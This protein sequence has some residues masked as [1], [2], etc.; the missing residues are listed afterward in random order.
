MTSTRSSARSGT[1]GDAWELAARAGFA[2]SG[3]LHVALGII[4][5]RIG[6]GAGGEADQGKALSGL[7]HSGPGTVLLWVATAA[8]V[9]LA[10]WQAAD[11][12]RGTET[13]DR[14]KAAGKAAVYLAV[15]FTAASIAMGS[16]SSDQDKQ[17]QGFASTLMQAPGG[18]LLVGAIGLGI[19]AAG[20]YHVFKGATRRF[21]RDL[22]SPSANEVGTGV[23]W[24]GTIGYVAKGVALGAVG[25]LFTYAAV[26]ADPDKAQGI[27]GAI[28]SLLGVPGGPVIVVLVGIGFAAYGVYSFA[29]ARYARM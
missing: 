26:T 10:G 15:A 5:V 6:L 22:R 9:A 2:V 17:A 1:S 12:I 28:E 14:A 13:A 4:I 27:D 19:V 8:L 29:R 25:V 24:L 18:P 23:R 21:E 3:A 7:G 20:G 11:A 16:G